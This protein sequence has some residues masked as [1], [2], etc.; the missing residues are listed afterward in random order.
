MWL[1]PPTSVNPF[2]VQSSMSPPKPHATLLLATHPE[3]Q[4]EISA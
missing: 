1:L 3:P 2:P 4:A